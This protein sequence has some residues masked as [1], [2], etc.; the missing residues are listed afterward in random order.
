MDGVPPAKA[1]WMGRAASAANRRATG[2]PLTPSD[3]GQS[4]SPSAMVLPLRG[5]LPYEATTWLPEHACP[6]R[7]L[8]LPFGF[9][10]ELWHVQ[11]QLGI[12]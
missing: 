4:V 9:Q 8:E 7:H 5:G 2:A 6:I 3:Q 12:G 10:V 11:L 1:D